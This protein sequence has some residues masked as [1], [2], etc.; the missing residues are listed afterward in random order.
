[1]DRAIVIYGPTAV[2]KTDFAETLA[3]QL[4]GEII[5]ADAAQFY[6]PLTIGT[7]KP[8]WRSAT[9]PHYLFDICNEP[10]DYSV[11]QYRIDAQQCVDEI[12]A[13]G[14]TPIFVGGSGFYIHALLFPVSNHHTGNDQRKNREIL[15]DSW[16]QLNAIDPVRAAAIHPHDSYR[17]SRALALYQQTKELPSALIPTYRPI[18]PLFLV[19]LSSE[20]EL[21][22]SRIQ[23]RTAQMLDAGWL[24]ETES[25]IGTSWESFVL[26]KKWIGY[27]E[28]IAY[29]KAGRP[30][31][32]FA[33]IK[34]AIIRRTWR[35]ARKQIAYF[36]ML[37]KKNQNTDT[38]EPYMKINLTSNALELYLKQLIDRI[39]IL[40]KGSGNE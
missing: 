7:A 16:E 30:S 29:S 23:A 12:Q 34:E 14:K 35:Y 10:T 13:R 21:L 15:N 24:K 26:R 5:N 19:E 28:L 20:P 39:I 32:G 18:I 1:M 22:K 33:A 36:R 25:F 38:Q 11:A 6:A 8:D 27:P 2:G 40:Q 4:N 31:E 9:V 37:E 17:I 3:Q